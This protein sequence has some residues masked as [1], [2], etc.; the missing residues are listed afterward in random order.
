MNAGSWMAAFM[1]LPEDRFGKCSQ[2][3]EIEYH[4][5][6]CCLFHH[7]CIALIEIQQKTTSYCRTASHQ[8]RP[9]FQKTG[10]MY[11]SIYT[12][13]IVRPL[14]KRPV[15]SST[16]DMFRTAAGN[17]T[18]GL[19]SMTTTALAWFQTSLSTAKCSLPLS[20]RIL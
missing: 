15:P 11:S 10:G 6:V 8:A 20:D 19:S 5:G 1:G 16:S 2:P 7:K 18:A 9:R 14:R 17:H 12:S 3:A 4:H 13:P